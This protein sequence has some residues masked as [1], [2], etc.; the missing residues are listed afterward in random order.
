[1][2]NGK[3]I[4]I[5]RLRDVKRIKN[6]K[7]L[8][9]EK[10]KKIFDLNA[11]KYKPYK[12]DNNTLFFRKEMK[13]EVLKNIL[14]KNIKPEW[15]A[16]YVY[17]EI[18][19]SK[20]DLLTNELID[21]AVNNYDKK[22]EEFYEKFL[23]LNY[24]QKNF[25]KEKGQNIL[26]NVEYLVYG[27]LDNGDL[28][29]FP[30]ALREI[31]ELK[32][33]SKN[34]IVKI[35]KNNK[36]IPNIP[37]ISWLGNLKNIDTEK[38]LNDLIELD[39][40]NFVSKQLEMYSV[41]GIDIKKEDF[42]DL[43]T[44]ELKLRMENKNSKN[45]LE[46]TKLLS[47][48]IVFASINNCPV[49]AVNI[50][51]N[52]SCWNFQSNFDNKTLEEKFDFLIL[53]HIS[54]NT[55]YDE[56]IEP[57]I[58]A[59]NN[60][61]FDDDYTDEE[62]NDD[63]DDLK[64]YRKNN[65]DNIVNILN[66]NFSTKEEKQSFFERRKFNIIKILKDNT[67]IIELFTKFLLKHKTMDED[68]IREQFHSNKLI[69]DYNKNV[70]EIKFEK[71]SFEIEKV[72]LIC[73]YTEIANKNI[74]NDAIK[75]MKTDFIDTLLE[76][77]Q[78]ID[79]SV[80][81][82][83]E[84][85]SEEKISW[86]FNADIHQQMA[87][88][89][90]TKYNNIVIQGPPGTGKT[91]TILNIIN[92][93]LSRNKKILIVSEKITAVDV[94]RT[95]VEK[96][97]PQLSNLLLNLYNIDNSNPS[98]LNDIGNKVQKMLSKKTSNSNGNK[99][100]FDNN[101]DKEKLLNELSEEISLFFLKDKFNKWK[102]FS[103]SKKDFEIYNSFDENNLKDALNVTD[104]MH[105]QFLKWQL[106]KN[107]LDEFAKKYQIRTI[108]SKL[109][110]K[111]LDFNKLTPYNQY[112]SHKY[113]SLFLRNS[114]KVCFLFKKKFKKEAIKMK[115]EEIFNDIKN[116]IMLKQFSEFNFYKYDDNISIINLYNDLK[117]SELSIE[118]IRKIDM[119]LSDVKEFKR[120]ENKLESNNIYNF[121]DINDNKSK[122]MTGHDFIFD[123]HCR[124]VQ[125]M[126]D[127]NVNLKRELLRFKDRKKWGM[128]TK[129]FFKEFWNDLYKIFPVVLSTPETLSNYA[130]L[131]EKM[132]DV[133]LI[134]EASQ[135]LTERAIPAL[136]RGNKRIISG[137]KNQLRPNINGQRFTSDEQ[138]DEKAE[139]W[140][141]ARNDSV[142]DLY[143]D[144]FNDS[145]CN[146]KFRLKIH[147]RSEKK[148]LIEFSNQ[149]FY[150]GELKFLEHT[151]KL[152]SN[153]A[154]QLF[155]VK[156]EWKK[157]ANII[158][159][160]KIIEKLEELFLLDKNSSIGVIVFTK[161]QANLIKNLLY[162]NTNNSVIL[163]RLNSS[164]SDSL[165][166][167]SIEDVQGEERNIIIFGITYGNNVHSYGSIS[168]EYG[169]NKINV[170]VTRAK[171]QMIIIK[172]YKEKEY[173][174]LGDSKFESSLLLFKFLEYV[175]QLTQNNRSLY[176]EDSVNDNDADDSTFVHH[177]SR[178]GIVISDKISIGQKKF[179][180]EKKNNSFFNAYYLV[181]QKILISPRENLW[182]Y[183]K[184]L[185][186]KGYTSKPVS[187]FKL[188]DFTKNI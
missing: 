19:N 77:N 26:F 5:Q 161:R 47:E 111:I 91:Q 75:I 167:K 154:I 89:N 138:L 149:E 56:I 70:V 32:I 17:K 92:E 141:L 10:S 9:S 112:N 153:K 93:Y 126:L 129:L 14:N 114:D 104:D 177:L 81:N 64:Q 140:V 66:E 29:R 6:L 31:T 48:Q 13:G 97:A 60:D 109:V 124:F 103:I 172:S 102:N 101:H 24:N 130:P 53:E 145:D 183:E 188:Y 134:D 120:I 143:N 71:N 98:F 151:S 73:E 39:E 139:Y 147:Y 180:I 25:Q 135:F 87:V 184:I 116:L 94:I 115:L 16:D 80:F 67:S 45:E 36:Y 128:K 21:S 132:F 85:F 95:R 79:N 12:L 162:K 136:Y 181:D 46:A 185:L 11:R 133:V 8:E 122:F 52:Y 157:Q 170:A 34:R 137:D 65:I 88:F 30:F 159:A 173:R 165:F 113:A 23:L 55:F 187:I 182:F 63:N 58:E 43:H 20:N 131:I 61:D 186:T 150:N 86:G 174:R 41:L 51:I 176:E 37:F 178:S 72:D 59:K 171:K 83:N 74:I 142:L 164:D 179:Y 105:S 155:D 38:Y 40:S 169:K 62:N 168:S 35:I 44:K 57:R 18:L 146:T 28:I 96:N 117:K 107:K 106:E 163:E 127:N 50:N 82:E 7:F 148:E 90:T 1:M 119:F 160:E 68:Q 100:I 84:M 158:E 76:N 125:R 54:N 4:I 156:G 121:F 166:I 123:N 78:N 15:M 2:K 108:D 110:L 49:D 27:K 175:E 42:S 3:E 69:D 152:F 33:D 144:I 22:T 99:P 118:K